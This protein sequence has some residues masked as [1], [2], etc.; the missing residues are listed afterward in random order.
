MPK[1]ITDVWGWVGTEKTGEEDFREISVKGKFLGN[2]SIKTKA[3]TFNTIKI[4]TVVASSDGAKNILTEWLAPNIGMVKM[5]IK[6]EGGGVMGLLR[7]ILGFS[8][9]EF[10]L[11]KIERK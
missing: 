8:S 1:S 10:L 2:E 4:E 11:T 6:V 3:G 9:I 5:T 7:D